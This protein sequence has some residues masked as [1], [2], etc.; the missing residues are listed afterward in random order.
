MEGVK[1]TI[2]RKLTGRENLK[3]AHGNEGIPQGTFSLE[4]PHPT[5]NPPPSQPLYCQ[6]V[7]F[8][9]YLNVHDILVHSS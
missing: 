6:K 7:V 3:E 9:A 8:A 1:S 4:P 2:D 5:L